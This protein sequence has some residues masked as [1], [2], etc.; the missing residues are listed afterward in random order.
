MEMKAKLQTVA[1]LQ[2]AKAKQ[3]IKDFR[4]PYCGETAQ[5]KYR[6]FCSQRCAQLHFGHWLNE[7]YRVPVVEFDQIDEFK[8]DDL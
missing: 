1:S 3:K 4:C 2:K 5:H 6:P 8:K 7:E